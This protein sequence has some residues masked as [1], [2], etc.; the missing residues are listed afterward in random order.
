M[1]SYLQRKLDIIRVEM[2]S[3]R[4]RKYDKNEN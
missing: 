3:N 1:S 2:K 4:N